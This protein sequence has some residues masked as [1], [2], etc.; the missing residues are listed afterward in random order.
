MSLAADI[1]NTL[2][3]LRAEAEAMM[4]TQ[5]RVERATGERVMN[6]VTY[7]YE[8]EM[9]TVYEGK[10]RV[11]FPANRILTGQVPGM[12]VTKQDVIA[13][14]PVDAPG[15]GDVTTN[16]VWVC[17]KNDPDPAMVGK[18]LRIAGVHYATDATARR[19]PME[20]IS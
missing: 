11:R 10:C 12:V 18:R 14:L 1:R 5:C 2:P 4:V 6:P 17:T 8:D 9:L 15:S 7:E 3:V 13:S 20:E 19:F 16:D